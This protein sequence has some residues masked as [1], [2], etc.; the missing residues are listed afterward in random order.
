MARGDYPSAKQD[1]FVLRLPDGMREEIK[2]KAEANSRSMNAE[3]VAA[4]EA[5]LAQPDLSAAQ[6][7]ELLD[8]ERNAYIRAEQLFENAFEVAASY[9]ALLKDT[10][11]QLLEYLN[12]AQYMGAVLRTVKEHLSP[13]VADLVA[14]FERASAEAHHHLS[15]EFSA[16]V[17]EGEAD[18]VALGNDLRSKQGKP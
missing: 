16:E 17:D 4:I 6:L 12:W 18:L 5:A 15:Q 13:E 10:K 9:K 8:E 14:H 2:A 3:I 7:R 1:Q 11:K